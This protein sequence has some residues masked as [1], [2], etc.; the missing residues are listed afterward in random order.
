[1]SRG[2]WAVVIPAKKLTPDMECSL[3]GDN[4][5]MHPTAFVYRA[6]L[7]SLTEARWWATAYGGQVRHWRRRWHA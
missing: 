5:D 1:M 6:R 7:T 4:I 2:R 3:V